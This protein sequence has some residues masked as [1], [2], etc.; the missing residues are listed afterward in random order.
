MSWLDKVDRDITIVTGDGKQY[1][2][3]W[4]NAS[5]SKDYNYGEF[6]YPNTSGSF[7]DRREPQGVRYSLT[8]YF[9]GEKNLEQAQKFWESSDNRDPWRIVHPLYGSIRVQPL[10]LEFDD[11]NYNTTIVSS[12]IVETNQRRGPEST[13]NIADQVEQSTKDAE[14]AVAQSY[15]ANAEPDVGTIQSLQNDISEL[16]AKAESD[17][18]GTEVATE[19]TNKA[20]AA[21]QTTNQAV[22]A[23]GDAI[24]SFVQFARLPGEIKG[25]LQTKLDILNRQIER[26][27]PPIPLNGSPT[28]KLQFEAQGVGLLTGKAL[29]LTKGKDELRTRSEI[30]R[31]SNSLIQDYDSFVRR[32]AT[33]STDQAGTSSSYYPD[34]QVQKTLER[35]VNLVAGSLFE[36][37]Y[38]AKR[39]KRFTTKEATNIFVLAHKLYGLD[40]QDKNLNL[41][42][43]Q[44]DLT[45]EEYFEIPE[46]RV[47]T[48]YA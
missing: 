1:K 33:L 19:Y 11:T 43:D 41:L 5:K 45:V 24:R 23:A 48:Y 34:H 10:S 30:V 6:N 9:T 16:R 22:G 7:I 36:L 13:I 3:L 2:P 14:D 26:L 32:L 44:N 8:L 31:A 46:G 35:S 4:A 38:N 40:E 37:I 21:L 15:E 28:E 18:P 42:I 12:T 47:I 27:T 25:D 20:Q 29:A 39:E 17:L